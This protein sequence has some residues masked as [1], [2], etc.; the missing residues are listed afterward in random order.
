[1]FLHPS[2]LDLIWQKVPDV[3]QKHKTDFLYVGRFKKEK[4][5]YY[6]LIFLKPF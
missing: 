3:I 2:E 6:L 4:G 5:S 1:M